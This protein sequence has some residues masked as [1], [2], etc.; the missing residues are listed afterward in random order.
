MQNASRYE[1]LGFKVVLA[2]ECLDLS[3]N[4]MLQRKPVKEIRETLQNTISSS[5][6]NHARK[7]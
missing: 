2:R 7:I 4:L 3:V 5:G 1:K 6:S